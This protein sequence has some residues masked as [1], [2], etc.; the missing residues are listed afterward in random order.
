MAQ[1]QGGAEAAAVHAG[2]AATVVAPASAAGRAGVAVVR[3]SGPA[4]GAAVDTL[5]PPRP[6]PRQ[7]VLRRIGPP[8]DP[9]DRGLV[10]WFPAPASFTGEDLVEFQVHGGRAVVDGLVDALVAL[11]G[12]RPAEPGEFSR[13]AFLNGKLD[14]TEV[15]A[16]AD[17]VAAETAAQRR[18]ALRQLGGALRRQY[19]GWRARLVRCLAHVE[20]DLDFPDEDLPAGIIAAVAPELAG[21]RQEIA[22]HLDDGGA[23]ERLRAGVAVAILGPPNAGKSSLLNRLARRDA[24]IVSHLAG[25]TRD[26]I[27]VHLD[28]D[29][30]PVAVWDTAGL[31]AGGDAIEAEGVRRSRARAAEADLRLVVLDGARWPEVPEAVADMIDATALVVWN[32]ADLRPAT[33]GGPP[34]AEP[35][36]I[37]ALTGAGLDMLER[38]LSERVA[39]L[40][41]VA[42]GLAPTR[43]RHRTALED[44][45]AALDRALAAP[46]P[47]LAAEDLRLAARA[48]GRITG[49]VDVEDLLDVVFRDF[50]IGK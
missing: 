2:A 19:D 1:A 7:A 22:R 36:W 11:P 16:V 49:R 47:E 30:V 37:S 18:Q 14:L 44:T 23:A 50:C 5:A 40:A 38:A 20:A 10:L 34:A 25:T 33:P 41:G 43:A 45:R 35:V 46:A 15:E 9:I 42:G 13:R 48:L 32:K 39:A 28:L 8:G 3:V 6:P 26:V 27:E 24:A 29:G 12:L 4:A 31:R 21:M 17:M